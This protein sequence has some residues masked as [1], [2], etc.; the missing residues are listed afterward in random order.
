[1]FLSGP[2]PTNRLVR[3][4]L[5]HIAAHLAEDLSPPTLAHRAGITTRHLNRLF[6]TH[7]GRTPARAV[8]A[9]RTEAAAHLARSSDLPLAAVAR[10]CGFT[11]ASTLREA[12]L[13]HYGLRGHDS[14][15]AGHAGPVRHVN[16]PHFS[17]MIATQ[18]TRRTA[19][20]GVAATAALGLTAGPANAWTRGPRI[21]VLLY[22]GFSLLDPAGP[23][24]LLSRLPGATVT[25]IA[26]HRGPVRSDTR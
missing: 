10:R 3:D 21:G 23:A 9:A 19:L 22:D 16:R 4:L 25:M 8:R 5:G 11:S 12:F 2:P 6:A 14:P 18:T 20:T 13:N 1:M 15:D 24:E 17:G 26:E 7:L